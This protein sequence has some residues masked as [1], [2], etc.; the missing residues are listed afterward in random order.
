MTLIDQKLKDFFPEDI[1]KKDLLFQFREKFN[2]PIYV[3]ENLILKFKQD[4]IGL[5]DVEIINQLIK[6]R[7]VDTK[8]SLKVQA[9]IRDQG[10]LVIIDKVTAKAIIGQNQYWA[11][12]VNLGA[13]KVR[14]SKQLIREYPDLLEK[15]LWAEVKIRYLDSESSLESEFEIEK[16]IPIQRT[17]FFL[18]DY[19]NKVDEFSIYQWS[20]ILLRS[21]GIEPLFLSQ[22]RRLLFLSRLIPFVEKN[23]NFIELGSRGTGKSFTYRQ[24]SS[25]ATLVSGG[26]TTVANLFYNMG[27]RQLGLVGK[28]DVV[29]FDEVAYVDFE[30]KTAIQILKDYMESGSFSRGRENMRGQAS[31]VFLGNINHDLSLIMRRSHLFEPLPK[32]L[33]DMALIDRFHFYLPGWEMKKLKE[34]DFTKHYGL[35]TDYLSMA[36]NRLRELDYT[37]L[38]DEYFIFDKNINTRDIRAIKKTVSGLLKLLH[39]SGNFSKEELKIY[40]ELATEG[41]KRVR[42]QLTKMGSFEYEDVSFEYYDKGTQQHFIPSLPED[43]IS[44]D[45]MLKLADPGVVYIGQILDGK[46]FALLKLKIKACSGSG[47]LLFVGDIDFKIMNLLRRTFLLIRDRKSNLHLRDKIKSRDFSVEVTLFLNQIDGDV[48]NAFFIAL[49]SLLNNKS[50]TTG[51]LITEKTSIYRKSAYSTVLNAIKVK[52]NGGKIKIL[53]PL[54]NDVFVEVPNEVIIYAP[55]FINV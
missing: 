14:I 16:L 53:L 30:D 13:R 33:Q 29:A 36:F 17:N 45:Y 46:E 7:L 8:E 23:Y 52:G 35:Q 40:F 11:E 48:S 26:K 38:L 31:M 22:R 41:R 39:P 3:I 21:I 15:G 4:D 19:Q 24:L 37:D 51:L 9:K 5:E 50:V 2:I 28:R 55:C 49:Y 54:A 12:L 20:C 6:E 44:R 27:T 32:I 34:K 47:K 1:L 18:E 25:E 43:K 42:T 10:N